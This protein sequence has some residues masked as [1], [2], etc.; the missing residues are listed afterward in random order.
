M[1]LHLDEKAR[2]Q[3]DKVNELRV[4]A[5]ELKLAKPPMELSEAMLK[6]ALK[7]S[8]L[9]VAVKDS[10]SGKEIRQAYSVKNVIASKVHAEGMG[11]LVLDDGTKVACFHKDIFLLEAEVV[12]IPPPTEPAKQPTLNA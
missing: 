6:H 9:N 7:E 3:L 11:R 1:A 8:G 2:A 4:L 12:M 5:A 10:K